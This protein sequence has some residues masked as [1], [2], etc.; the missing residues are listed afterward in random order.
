MNEAFPEA[1]ATILTASQAGARTGTPVTSWGKEVLFAQLC[2]G[3][4]EAGHWPV[5]T[6]SLHQ[7]QK[8]CCTSSCGLFL[9]IAWHTYEHFFIDGKTITS[10]IFWQYLVILMSTH[11]SPFEFPK[12]TT[13]Q[14]PTWEQGKQEYT[15]RTFISVRMSVES[16]YT[17]LYNYVHT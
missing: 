14:G 1:T 12:L 13:M 11:C 17:S 5:G 6:H 9:T 16:V 7:V 10:C 8:E 4:Y 3:A 2:V 15:L